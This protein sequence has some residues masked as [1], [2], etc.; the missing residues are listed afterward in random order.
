MAAKITGLKAEIPASCAM[1][2]GS[3]QQIKQH[4]KL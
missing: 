3:E 2:K 1:I 4:T